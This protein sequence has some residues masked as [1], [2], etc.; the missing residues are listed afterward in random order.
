MSPSD[1][2][3]IAAAVAALPPL[4][5]VIAAYG[6]AARK[7]LGQHFLLDLNLTA[8]IARAAGRIEGATVIEVGPGPGGLTRAL[9]LAGAGR[10]VAIERDMR[11][12]EVLAPLVAAAG[13]RLT[14]VAEDARIADESALAPGVGLYVIS[15]LPY[16]VG[17]VLI[18]K[19]LRQVA[20]DPE[21]YAGI[22]VLLQKEVGARL[23]AGP[24]SKAYGRLSVMCQ[25][26]AEATACFDIGA[27]AFTPPPKVDSTVIRLVPLAHPRADAAWEDMET[28]TRNAFGQRRKM[29]RSSLKPLFGG[30]AE[31]V[32]RH[33][34][35]RGEARAEELS[36]EE[37]AALA[38]ICGAGRRG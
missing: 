24:R 34:G 10:I 11:C 33:A 17:T 14:L 19:W 31:T 15:N 16:N 3:S 29:L 28:V 8:R 13:G 22:V 2:A 35:I 32:L 1:S 25:W 4:R 38:R 12:A 20:A 5:E 26:L 36:V 37:F 27:R 30:G 7:G 18:L 6:L 21:R 9:L 23:V